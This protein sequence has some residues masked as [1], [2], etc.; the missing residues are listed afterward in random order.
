MRYMLD[1]N[2]CIYLIRLK[3]E[4][5]IKRITRHSPEDIVL[6]SITVSELFYG[7]YK[8]MNR[9]QNMKALSLFLEPFEVLP[10]DS[11]AAKIYGEIRSDL[12]RKGTPIG[13]M[14]LLIGVHALSLGV[15]LVT[16]NTREF[17]RIK[18]LKVVDWTK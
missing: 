14:D 13:S 1:T 18:G 16:N 3:P 7:V 6:S 8:S 4:R 15:T 12:E 2:I 5:L 10:Y 11:E 17:K 9:K